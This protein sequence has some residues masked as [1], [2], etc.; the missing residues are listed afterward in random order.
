MALRV[1]ASTLAEPPTRLA[2]N[3]GAF[4]SEN[5]GTTYRLA[6]KEG[7][8]VA[9]HRRYEDIPLTPSGP[10]TFSSD[11][12]FFRALTFTRA[13]GRV[14]ELRVTN[15]RARNLRFVKL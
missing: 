15:N 2:D 11:T 10:D 7:R 13:G 3:E 6:V 8:L 1:A 14:T 4:Y 12:W 9:Q 5:L